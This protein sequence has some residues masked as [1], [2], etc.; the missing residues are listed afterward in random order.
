MLGKL[1]K[2]K[3]LRVHG[4]LKRSSTVSG[5]NVLKARRQR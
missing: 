5:R 3:R 4:F 2:R 1:K